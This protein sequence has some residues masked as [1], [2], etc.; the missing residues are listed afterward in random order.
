MIPQPKRGPQIL[1]TIAEHGPLDIAMLQRMVQPDM[2]KKNLRK[3]LAVL[4]E[5]DQIEQVWSLS[6]S[7]LYF[8]PQSPTYRR[9]MSD[10]IGSQMVFVMRPQL[11]RD[12]WKLHWCEYWIA[13]IKKQLPHQINIRTSELGKDPFARDE[14]LFSLESDLALRP[15]FLLTFPRPD[16]SKV[17][18]AFEMEN[19]PKSYRRLFHKF[20]KY[21]GWSQL[22]G[23]IYL[24]DLGCL[25]EMIQPLPQTGI[26]PKQLKQKRL[27]DNF[28]LFS[29]SLDGGGP[30]LPR[31]LNA[32]GQTTSFAD[33]Y[34]CLSTA[35]PT[36]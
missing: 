7:M 35:T 13:A 23:L 27:N 31:L 1:R 4:R 28:F 10:V 17:T 18:I 2:P 19:I 21:V 3:A 24:S 6:Q 11:R 9:H 36:E 30:T 8:T 20:G 25:P 12:K 33:W 16:E 5:K 14:L 32:T 29:T 34:G 22:D 15:D 26:I